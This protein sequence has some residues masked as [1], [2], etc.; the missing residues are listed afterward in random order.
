MVVVPIR[1]GKWA[2]PETDEACPPLG[3]DLLW[4]AEAI[5]TFIFGD[6]SKRRAVYH[7]SERYD[8]PAFK[9]GRILCARRSVLMAWVEQ[10]EKD[11][12]AATL[13]KRG[14]PGR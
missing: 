2:T 6:R 8:L 5:A 14:P 1:G 13:T 4:G 7:L 9:M 10:R 11:S 12:V 3:D